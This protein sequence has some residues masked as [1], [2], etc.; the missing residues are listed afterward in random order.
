MIGEVSR[1]FWAIRH[2]HRTKAELDML[3]GDHG[4]NEDPQESDQDK[5]LHKRLQKPRD[6]PPP[7]ELG[8]RSQPT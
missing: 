7:N 8:N 2:D 3:D 1:G 4:Q 5:S 6:V